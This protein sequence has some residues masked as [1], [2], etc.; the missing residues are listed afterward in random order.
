[1]RQ[2]PHNLDPD[3]HHNLCL[4]AVD[5]TAAV[6][7]DDDLA[8]DSTSAD[9]YRRIEQA[10]RFL[11]ENFERQ[12]SLAEVARAV[13]LSPFHFERLFKLWAGVTPKRFLQF[14]TLEYAKDLLRDSS[15]V[16][17]AAHAAGLSGPGRLHD[18]FVAVDAVTPGEFKLGG[19]GLTI[20]YGVHET[21]FGDA[22]VAAT[23]RGIVRFDFVDLPQTGPSREALRAD[24]AASWPHA[25]LQEQPAVTRPYVQQILAHGRSTAETPLHLLLRGTNFQ[26]KVWQALLAIPPGHAFSYEQVAHLI[27]RPSAVRAVAHAIAH[28][29]IAYLIPCHRVLRKTGELGGYRWG[30]GRKQLLLAW[31]GAQRSLANPARTA[32]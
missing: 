29:P 11:S 9:H 31:E 5:L 8:H 1:M 23:A 24:L 12:P 32:A 10:L 28:N 2:Q 25:E 14:L 30:V 27:G 22:F 4:P 6:P 16:L 21:P 17:A 3:H 15:S 18:L 20:F 19:A 26:L 7:A 13:H